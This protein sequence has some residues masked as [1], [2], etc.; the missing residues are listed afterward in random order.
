MGKTHIDVIRSSKVKG[1]SGR[2]YAYLTIDGQ[3]P[4]P[5]VG[6]EVVVVKRNRMKVVHVERRLFHYT[7]DSLYLQLFFSK[8]D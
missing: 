3:L 6:D 5:A 7:K 1:R 2:T 8:V 4:T